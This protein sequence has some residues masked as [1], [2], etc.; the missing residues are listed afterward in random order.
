MF[1]NYFFGEDEKL[2]QFQIFL[3]DELNE[4][5]ILVT[6]P[7][8]AART[9]L[10]AHTLHLIGHLYRKINGLNQILSM[11]WIFPYYMESYVKLSMPEMEMFDYKINYTNHKNYHSRSNG[12]KQLSPVRIFSNILPE[13]LHFPSN[14][15]YKFC[16]I[17]KR[18]TS[19]ENKHC[20]KCKK[21][22]SKNGDTY[23]HCNICD[24]CV[25]PF[26]KHCIYCR[27][28][29]QTNNH[30]CEDYQK[31]QKCNICLC[32]GHIETNCD[33]WFKK[34][35]KNRKLIEQ[36]KSKATKAKCSYCFLCFK[37]GHVELNCR[38]RQHFLKEHTFLGKT[39][40][41]F[42]TFDD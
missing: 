12:R 5:T 35:N 10:L 11:M 14:E 1:N 6:D 30:I 37:M 40:N 41:I 25:K 16:S 13:M 27:R 15:G 23:I 34:I 22:T 26:Y 7:P 8:F 2:K 33:E 18:W 17:C 4:K 28:C 31:H 29:T 42:C 20:K 38:S 19:S 39:T 21:C 3:K 24:I 36:L 9:E 32:R